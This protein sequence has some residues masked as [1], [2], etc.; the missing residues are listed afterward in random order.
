MLCRQELDRSYLCLLTI[1]LPSCSCPEVPQ[2]SA[3]NSCCQHCA[4]LEPSMLCSYLEKRVGWVITHLF[5]LITE[6]AEHTLRN[7]CKLMFSQDEG[8][9]KHAKHLAE[10]LTIMADE[11]KVSS[12]AGA[13]CCAAGCCQGCA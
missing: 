1:A 2:N 10:A 3:P 11:F 13:W 4:L 7:V 5:N 8:G 9:K 6:D 12:P